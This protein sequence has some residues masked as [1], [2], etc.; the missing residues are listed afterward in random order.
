MRK[1][2]DDG[3]TDARDSPGSHFSVVHALAAQSGWCEKWDMVVSSNDGVAYLGA[4][5]VEEQNLLCLE[6]K[7]KNGRLLGSSA[8]WYSKAM[9]WFKVDMR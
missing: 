1:A 8:A 4:S 5:S 3:Y 7:F 6:W 9:S 2:E